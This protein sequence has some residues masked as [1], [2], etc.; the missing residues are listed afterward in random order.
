MRKNIGF[1]FVAAMAPSLVLAGPMNSV[2]TQVQSVPT[3]D[4]FGLI[5]LIA[6]IG[7]VAGL[8]MRRRGK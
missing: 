5:G 3:L 6:G 7:I 1:L 8:V 2:F 4:E